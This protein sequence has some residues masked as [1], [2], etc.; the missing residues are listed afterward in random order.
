MMTWKED[1][2]PIKPVAQG[3]A[4]GKARILLCVGS[5]LS[6]LAKYYKK[7]MN[8]GKNCLV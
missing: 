3:K 5:Y 2:E 4:I 6:L 1:Q 7:E 8:S